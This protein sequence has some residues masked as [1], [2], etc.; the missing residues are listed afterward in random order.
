M[1]VIDAN[2]LILGRLASIVAHRLLSG[3]QI[4]I[5]NAE[6]AVV[7][8]SPETTVSKY[9]TMRKKG[10]KERGPYYPKRS[11]MILKRTIRGMLPYKKA[12]G[13]AA[14]GRLRVYVGTPKEL[15]D[16]ATETLNSAG[17]SRLSTIKITDLEKVSQRLGTKN[18]VR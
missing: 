10:S 16:I 15:V 6:K 1:T 13:K 3:E 7:S 2:G 9:Q 4:D 18:R 11:D 8:G 12:F 14:F 5:I 17:K